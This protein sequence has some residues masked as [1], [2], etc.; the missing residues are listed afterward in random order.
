MSATDLHR[1]PGA[2]PGPA[3]RLADVARRAGVSVITASRALR[4]PRKVAAET[5]ARVDEAVRALGYVPNLVAGALASARTRSVAVLLPTIVSPIF[6]E[7]IN[8]LTDALEAEGYAILMAQSGYDPARQER[9]LSALLGR[10]PE[11]VVLVGSPLTPRARL[12]LE[13]AAAAGAAVVETWELPD[14]PVGAAVGFDNAAAGAAVA[15]H[16]AASGRRRLAF[17]GSAEG[18]AED[19]WRGFLQG[20]RRSGL[21]APRRIRLTAPA[22]MDDAAAAAVRA[23]PAG[24]DGL[25]GAD[26]VFAANDVHA[27]GLLSGFRAAG[28]T[29]PREVAV[30]GLG[31]LDIARHASP[32]LTTIGIDGRAI[33]RGAAGLILARPPEPA[34]AGGAA[35]ARRIDVGFTLRRR[36]SG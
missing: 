10:R 19:R 27:V 13:R 4:E 8:G 30:V 2:A 26:A 7:T 12:M 24:Q 23:H 28:R 29:V 34:G 21:A 15:A 18:R 1:S 11:A 9:A 33:G 22:T 31:D 32:P 16:F 17:V 35:P 36:D 25:A 14:H 3:P 6:A 20:A 5:R